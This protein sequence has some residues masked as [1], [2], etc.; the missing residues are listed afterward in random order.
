MYA[1]FEIA[2]VKNI[3]SADRHLDTV[4]PKKAKAVKSSLSRVDPKKNLEV[5]SD[6]DIPQITNPEKPQIGINL[7]LVASDDNQSENI[8][9][10]K[11]INPQDKVVLQLEA[12]DDQSE[13]SQNSNPDE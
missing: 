9:E 10:S 11:E 7:P 6:P 12:S 4:S 1:Q 2:K 3:I 8:S 5:E 13:M